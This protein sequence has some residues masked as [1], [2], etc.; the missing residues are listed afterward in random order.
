MFNYTEHIGAAY[1]SV[2]KMLESNGCLKPDC[3]VN[4]QVP[5]E[6]G[7]LPIKQQKEYFNVFP[8]VFAG[9]NPSS[10]WRLTLSYTSRIGR[11]SYNQ[12]N[13]FRAYIDAH[14]SVEG[15]PDL[16]PE[17]SHQVALGVNF[18]THFNLALL[19]AHTKKP[20]YRLRIT[21]RKETNC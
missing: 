10:S 18:K 1:A 5:W 20:S 19:Y 9:Y 12:L 7:F 4:L 15:N 14:S 3:G 21:T 2:G 17:L 6:I 8:T 13:P 11:P 16:D